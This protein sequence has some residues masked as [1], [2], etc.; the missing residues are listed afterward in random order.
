MRIRPDTRGLVLLNV[1]SICKAGIVER[2]FRDGRR[3]QQTLAVATRAFTPVAPNG[4]V[5]ARL[6]SEV[7]CR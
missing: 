5:S 2:V 7:P 4:A 6:V 3:E 1:C